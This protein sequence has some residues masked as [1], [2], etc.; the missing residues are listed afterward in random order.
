M[1][2]VMTFVWVGIIR[3]YIIFFRIII[4]RRYYYA[5]LSMYH[6]IRSNWLTYR[7]FML[8]HKYSKTYKH[9]IGVLRKSSRGHLTNILKNGF[10]KEKQLVF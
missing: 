9:S 4:I 1:N 5:A 6:A 2:K 7:F 8:S 10:L 3:L